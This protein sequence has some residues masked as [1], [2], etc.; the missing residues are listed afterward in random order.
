[1]DS[2]SLDGIAEA[3]KAL[4][5]AGGGRAPESL[6]PGELVGV[7][8]AFGSLLRHVNAAFAP[9]AAEI[10]RQSR[11]E[12]GRD[13][14]A[15]KQGFRTPVAL[16][17]ATT[18]SS[19]GEAIKIVQVGEATAPRRT[20][21]GEELPARHA[22]V[23]ASVTA[24][25]LSVTAAAAIVSMLDRVAVRVDAGR[26]ADAEKELVELAPGLRA[27]ELSRLLTHAE[28][29]LDPDG[30]EPRQEEAR[31]ERHF[32][33][34]ERDGRFV[35]SGS[36]DIESGAPIKAVMDGMITQ[37]F[38]RNET[39]D[40]A[41]HDQRS[42][43]QMKADIFS[44]ICRH[45][46]G[47]TEVPTGPTTT[48]VVRM[49]LEELQTGVG[50]ATI[51]GVDQPVPASFVRR[52]AAD[53]QI[54][55]CVLGGDSTILD[56]GREKRLF[57]PAQKLALAERDG[58]CA[59]CGAPAAQT[60]VHHIRWWSHQGTT[61]LSNGILL[62]TACHHIVHDEGWEITID[63]VGVDAHVWFIP[64]PWI[65]RQQ[66]PRSGGRHRYRLSA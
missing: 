3:L 14:L 38:R 4:T 34:K 10:S 57:T 59:R 17:Q 40:D 66:T 35:L 21:T 55:P 62:C 48:V 2:Y 58:G 23:A 51:D 22:H 29:Y 26:L 50:T 18:G 65:D 33:I 5:A 12:L 54:I 19:V 41:T 27:D 25:R 63:G 28:A 30:L 45:A 61:D 60:I 1:M 39:A 6:T 7:N 15:K 64:P 11:A 43:R 46:L 36:F 37:I 9:V 16:I 32:D 42:V 8:A 13:S 53:L 47:C 52:T 31:A 44:D 49:T 24:G 56:W 20:L